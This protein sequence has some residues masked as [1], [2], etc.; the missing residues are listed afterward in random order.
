MTKEKHWEQIFDQASA[1]TDK[2][3]ADIVAAEKERL[4]LFT[5]EL[6]NEEELRK[7]ERK[8]LKREVLIIAFKPGLIP[9]N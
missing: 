8:E 9:K 7:E 5:K 6:Q 1:E 3:H 4:D 2:N